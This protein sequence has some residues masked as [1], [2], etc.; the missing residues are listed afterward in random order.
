MDR[1]SERFHFPTISLDEMK[2]VSLMR[3]VDTKYVLTQEQLWP[4]LEE[5]G[6]AYYVQETD[7]EQWLPYYTLYYDTPDCAMF[8]DH[9][10]GRPNRRKVRVRCYVTSGQ[11]FLEVKKKSGNGRTKKK[12][13]SVPD[14]AY[15]IRQEDEFISQHCQYP[16]ATLEKKLE[17]RFLRCTLVGK[18]MDE[19]VTIDTNLS[20]HNLKNDARVSLDDLVVVELKT[21][22]HVY[23]RMREVLN[24]H[25]LRT[26]AFSKYCMAMVL[27]DNEIKHNRF[28]MRLH[29]LSR[30][31]PAVKRYY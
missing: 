7:G 20:F 6:D 11:A 21:A 3:R 16:S 30:R 1:P 9:Q 10:R 22:G 23:S 5:L 17:N 29:M 8:S 4:V 28:K 26:S 24:D 19:R 2:K 13:V 25:L 15:D 14:A 27:T 18:N 31:I 12:R